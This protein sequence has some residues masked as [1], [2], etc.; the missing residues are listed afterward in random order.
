MDTW[1]W[2][3]IEHD[4]IAS[5]KEARDLERAQQVQPK[6]LMEPWLRVKIIDT[7]TNLLQMPREAVATQCSYSLTATRAYFF[8]WGR[9]GAGCTIKFDAEHNGNYIDR[10]LRVGQVVEHKF[11][12]EINILFIGDVFTHG[13]SILF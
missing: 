11:M 13:T 12:D 9:V 8:P 5:I 6:E 1:W 4:T 3:A 2:G 10:Y 7:Y